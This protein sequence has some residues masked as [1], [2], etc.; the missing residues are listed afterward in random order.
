MKQIITSFILIFLF[1]QCKSIKPDRFSQ[2]LVQE[3]LP[4][5]YT[6]INV[7]LEIPF[8]QIENRINKELSA[9][10]WQ[11]ESLGIGNGLTLDFKA[12]PMGGVSIFSVANETVGLTLPIDLG[13]VVKFEKKVLGQ[14]LATKMP[15][16]EQ[17]KP[18]IRFS[19]KVDN[20][21]NYVIQDAQIQDLGNVFK[22]SLLGF[23]VDLS[24]V[25]KNQLQKYLSSSFDLDQIRI[26]DI[27]SMAQNAWNAMHSVTKINTSDVDAFL[28][29][30]PQNIYFTQAFTPDRKLNLYLGIAGKMETVVGDLQQVQ[31]S[32]MPRLEENQNTKGEFEVVM[33]IVV[34]YE[35]LEN[36]L[37][38]DYSHKIMRLDAKTEVIPSQFKIENHGSAALLTFDFM[39]NRKDKKDVKGKMLVVAKPVFD[40]KREAVVLEDIEVDVQT[41]G[42]FT[43][44]GVLSKR[45]KIVKQIQKLAVFSLSEY[46]NSAKTEISK[47]Q[48]LSTEWVDFEVI[49]PSFEVI[50]IYTAQD[51]IQVVVRSKG[52]VQA[53]WNG[54]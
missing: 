54:F 47:Q 22:Y 51:D 24:S 14:V 44:Y 19:P 43:R 23:E 32:P 41:K 16:Q 36:F 39:A 9:Q 48:R 33:P 53:K 15:F 46:I 26:L 21:W 11:V 35:F 10:L 18:D 6:N 13:G 7:P 5:V 1:S 49:Q 40:A 12:I 42:F 3:E 31:L 38:Q 2:S 45:R 34:G 29:S 27:R 28:Y 50:G 52:R 8:D 25:I 37:N 30:R 17:L 20:Q 4:V